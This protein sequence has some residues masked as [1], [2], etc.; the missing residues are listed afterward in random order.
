MHKLYYEIIMYSSLLSGKF[1]LLY[2]CMGFMIMGT[3][4]GRDECKAGRCMTSFIIIHYC[5]RWWEVCA[6][7]SNDH[8]CEHHANQSWNHHTVQINQFR[9]HHTVQIS[10][11]ES[12]HHANQF[13][14]HHTVQISSGIIPLC[15]SV[16]ESSH[17][18]NQF[19]NHPTVQ[20]SSS[21][22]I[23]GIITPCK[24]VPE[25]SHCANQFR[26]HHTMQISSGIITPCKSVRGLCNN[27][28]KTINTTKMVSDSLNTFQKLHQCIHT[29]IRG[30]VLEK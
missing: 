21:S 25:S 11:P 29:K 26:N 17:R 18:A 28:A 27:Y 20:I 16:P 13:R 22:G 5:H 12:S 19:W 30:C 10:N 1:S 24:S 9:N 14:N 23:I 7:M 2:Q 3:L 8:A 4:H 6:Y 15:K